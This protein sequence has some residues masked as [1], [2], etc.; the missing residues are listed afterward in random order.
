MNIDPNASNSESQNT[1]IAKYLKAGGRLTP[2]LALTLFGSFRLAAR[3]GQLRAAG[4]N[5]RTDYIQVRNEAGRM[6]TIGEYSLE[7]GE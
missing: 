5:I 4:M 7:A 2:G 3:I 1:Q 6:I